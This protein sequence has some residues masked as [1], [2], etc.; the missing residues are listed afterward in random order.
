MKQFQTH[1]VS[2]HSGPI[3]E[4]VII[5]HIKSVKCIIQKKGKKSNTHNENEITPFHLVIAS[6]NNHGK[7]REKL[8]ILAVHGKKIISVRA[9]AQF[10]LDIG[11]K[12]KDLVL[13]YILY[14]F[15]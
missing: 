9:N 8:S 6:N 10:G 7:L 3:Y 11:T 1:T 13:L 14:H 2:L 12:V 5:A 4:A 15:E